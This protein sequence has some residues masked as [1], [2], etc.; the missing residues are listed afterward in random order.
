MSIK[1]LSRVVSLLAFLTGVFPVL[2]AQD[3]LVAA[4]SRA[5]WQPSPRPALDADPKTPVGSRGAHLQMRAN[6]V[7]GILMVAAYSVSG[8]P[9]LQLHMQF[10]SIVFCGGP[11]PI[12]GCLLDSL[13]D[14]AAALQK[15]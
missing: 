13:A 7:E 11:A 14:I 8:M 10:L 12:S 9:N 5:A 1:Q 6:S 4:A 2:S 3:G 15:C